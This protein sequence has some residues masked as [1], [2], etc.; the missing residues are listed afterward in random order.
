MKTL[1]IVN[2][3]AK[4]V[5]CLEHIGPQDGLLLIEDAVSC[6]TQNLELESVEMMVLEDDLTARGL[7]ATNSEWQRISY[8][9]FVENT[10]SYDKNVSWL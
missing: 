9:E 7:G 6:A 2:N 1:F 10:F 4:L 8:Q 3:P 5:S